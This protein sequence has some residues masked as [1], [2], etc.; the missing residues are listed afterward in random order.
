MTKLSVIPFFFGWGFFV[1]EKRTLKINLSIK[2]DSKKTE[3]KYQTTPITQK[4]GSSR[5]GRWL[6]SGRS[7]HVNFKNVN[8]FS[9]GA[10]RMVQW[11]LQKTKLVVKKIKSRKNQKL[12]FL[13]IHWKCHTNRLAMTFRTKV[14]HDPL[15]KSSSSKFSI[16]T[17]LICLRS[18]FLFFPW[19]NGSWLFLS[20]FHQRSHNTFFPPFLSNK[21]D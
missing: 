1:V 17:H 7:S 8:N 21:H 13:T 12:M 10:L 3:K 6:T 4:E 9:V 15:M 5:L 14:H 16:F 19:K 11:S 18:F 2:W 20:S